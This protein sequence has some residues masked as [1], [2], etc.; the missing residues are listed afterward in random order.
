MLQV[1]ISVG[2]GRQELFKLVISVLL[3]IG[4]DL[5]Y[6]KGTEKQRE[7]EILENTI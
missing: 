2:C 5:E 4:N 7:K 6:G 1:F 3:V